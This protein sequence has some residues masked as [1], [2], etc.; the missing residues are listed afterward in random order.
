MFENVLFMGLK[1]NGP[2]K[3]NLCVCVFS[4]FCTFDFNELKRFY[5]IAI[6]SVTTDL[7][8]HVFHGE[9]CN[10][11]HGKFFFTE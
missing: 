6:K 10:L 9:Y 4:A 1:N 5:N 3:P 8:I 7:M 2:Q 11:A